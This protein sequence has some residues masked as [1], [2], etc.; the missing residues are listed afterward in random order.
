M[1]RLT[2]IL[3]FGVL[4]ALSESRAALAAQ[5]EAEYTLALYG[6]SL[7]LPLNQSVVVPFDE[8]PSQQAVQTFYD[9]LNSGDWQPLITALLAFRQKHVLN[10]WLYYQVVRKAAQQIA[11]KG[12]NYHRYT[13]YKWFFLCKS[14]YDATLTLENDQLRFYVRSDENVYNIPYF[15]RGDK[16]YVCLN[17]HDYPATKFERVKIEQIDVAVPEATSPFSYKVTQ[18]PDFTPADY[19]AREIAFDY[20]GKPYY[21]SV[22]VNPQVQQVFTNYPVVDYESYFNIPLSSTTYRSLIPLLKK[23]VEGIS[24]KDG[25]DFLMRFTRNAFLYQEDEVTFGKEKRMSPEQTLLHEYSDCDDRAALFFFLVKEI[26]DRPMIVLLYP[27]H[28]TIAV[29]FPESGTSNAITYKGRK[30]AVCEPTPQPEDLPIGQLSAALKNV[31]YEV[32]YEYNPYPQQ[33]SE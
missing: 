33:V 17:L 29:H 31:P 21:F 4:M 16:Q 8:E 30:Y 14:G 7:N 32:A 3:I 25:V 23:N 12:D 15:V 20:K 2:C 13:L 24:D 1:W 19:T 9:E 11:P 28:V 27:T 26:Y 5:G 10:D 6:D 22:M 18:M